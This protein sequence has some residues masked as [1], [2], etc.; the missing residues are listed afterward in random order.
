MLSTA[1]KDAIRAMIYIAKKQQDKNDF[2]SIKEIAKELNLSF[3]FLSKILQKLVKEGLLE[4]YRGPNGGVKLS[5]DISDISIYDI[6]VSIDGDNIFKSCI[7][8]FEECSDTKPCAIHNR[9][10][11][12]RE[13]LFNL[14]KNTTLEEIEEEIEKK[15]NIKI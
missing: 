10:T 14:F 4:S 15:V 11:P 5:K 9:W 1:C 6:I 3:Y 2:I 7:L 12:E 13:R 8:G